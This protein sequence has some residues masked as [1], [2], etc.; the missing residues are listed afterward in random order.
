MLSSFKV[1]LLYL[2]F[3][4][5]PSDPGILFFVSVIPFFILTLDYIDHVVQANFLQK[6]DTKK[7]IYGK[8]IQIV[9]CNKGNMQIFFLI[10]KIL[11][12]LNC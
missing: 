9:L 3:F 7:E 2:A 1:W 8:Y 4:L 5:V 11:L 10:N 12:M 6:K